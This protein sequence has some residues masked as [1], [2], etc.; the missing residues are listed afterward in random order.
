MSN[1]LTFEILHIILLN[2]QGYYHS[3]EKFH[4]NRKTVRYN[5]NFSH[6]KLCLA[7]ATHNL[8]WMKITHFSLMLPI[9][10]RLFFIHSKL[11]LLTQFPASN[12]IKY[13][14]L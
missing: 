9:V 13:F 11:E 12:D 10:F 3:V 7:L 2:I 8:K 6:L 1:C 4:E 14:Y 5:Y